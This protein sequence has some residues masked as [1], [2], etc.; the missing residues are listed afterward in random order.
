MDEN[1][2]PTST[3]TPEEVKAWND[4]LK[5]FNYRQN[6]DGVSDEELD[7]GDGS[8]S[9]NTFDQYMM[10]NNK[11]YQ[12]DAMTKKMQ[13]YYNDMYNTDDNAMT[14]GI[15][16]K[17]PKEQLSK[18]DGRIG[19][20]TKNYYIPTYN[21]TRVVKDENTGQ[22]SNVGFTAYHDPHTHQPVFTNLNGMTPEEAGKHYQEMT[23]K[24]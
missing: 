1:P 11:P 22:T 14:E 3:P 23:K 15:R 21:H 7:K 5:Y 4:Y 18:Q 2:T 10:L 8:Y 24:K 20:L 13:Q 19:S 12:Y 6:S 16:S 17:Y 9:R